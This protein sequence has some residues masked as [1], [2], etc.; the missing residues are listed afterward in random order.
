MSKNIDENVVEMRFDNSN[1]EKNVKTSMSTLDKL[2]QKLNLSGASK[3]LEELDKAAKGL[4]FATATRGVEALQLKI[5]NL[6]IVGVT[7]ISNITNSVINL[8]KSMLNTLTGISAIKSGF[9]EY[10]TQLGSIQTIMANTSSKGTTLDE[11]NA[12]LAELNHYADKT[13]YN[14]T[15]MTRNIGTFTAA[16]V[17]LN[18]AVSSIKG[19]ANLAAA[20]GSSS[21]QASTAMYQLSQA[22]AAGK[23]QLMDWNSVVNAGMGGEL[24][25]NALKRTAE[26]FGTDVDGM[27]QKYGSFRESLTN[28]GWLTVD[29]LTET[30]KQISGAYTEADLIAQGYTADQA[31]AI[32]EL[33]TTAENAATKVKTFAELWDTLTEAAGSGWTT[34]WSLIFGDFEYA[35]E[36]LT[37]FSD[38]FSNIIN[39]MSDARNSLLKPALDSNWDKLIDK[40][41]EAGVSSSD[42]SEKVKEHL[43]ENGEDV[44]ALLLEYGTLENA[45]KSGK[46]STDALKQAVDDLSVSYSDLSDITGVFSL[47]SGFESEQGSE[48]VKK[49][50]RQLKQLGYDLGTF[51]DQADG[52]DGQFGSMTEAAIKAFQEAHG[53]EADGII[54]PETLKALQDSVDK[55][56]DLKTSVGDLIDGVDELGGRDR[57]FKS[58]KNIITAVAKVAKTA[59]D[60]FSNIFPPATSEDIYNAIV[61]FE[62]FTEKLE[63][64]DETAQKLERVFAG[65]FSVVKIASNLI[66]GP[67]KIALRIADGICSLFGTSLLDL[68]AKI[69]DSIVAFSDWLDGFGKIPSVTN[70]VQAFIQGVIDT[71]TNLTTFFQNG[72]KGD[73]WSCFDPLI[74]GITALSDGIWQA[75]QDTPV[76]TFVNWISGIVESIKDS[77]AEAI[78]SDF[79]QGIVNGIEDGISLI[80]EWASNIANNLLNTVKDILGIHSPSTEG[81]AIGE[82][83]VQGIINGITGF[84]SNLID[85]VTNVGKTILDTVKGLDFGAAIPLLIIGG[86]VALL[87]IL[88][89]KLDKGV[90][91]VTGPF[92]DLA[93]AIGSIAKS[94]KTDKMLKQ[95]NAFKA[96]AEGIGI[97]SAAVLGLAYGISKDTGAVWGAVGVIATL[98]AVMAALTVVISKF[99]GGVSV[100]AAGIG[101]MLTGI[102]TVVASMAGVVYILGKMDTGQVIQGTIVCGVLAAFVVAIIG[103]MKYFDGKEK[104]G[105]AKGNFG[106]LLGVAIAIGAMAAVV[107]V[108][109]S[110]STE[111]VIR[112]VICAAALS[113]LIVALIKVSKSSEMLKG[114]GTSLLGVAVVLGVMAGM[115]FIFSIMNP[116][117]FWKGYQCVA[118]LS[119][120]VAGLLFVAGLAARLGSGNKAAGGLLGVAAVLAVMGGI[121]IILGGMSTEQLIKGISCVGLFSLFVAGLLIASGYAGKLSGGHGI[122]SFVGIALVLAVMAGCVILLGQMDEEKIQN[123]VQAMTWMSSLAAIL[124]AVSKKARNVKAGP[125]IALSVTIGLLAASLAVLSLMDPTGVEAA[126]RCMAEVMAMFVAVEYA[127]QFANSSVGTIVALTVAIG[128]IAFAIGIL[129]NITE[130]DSALASAQSISL[131]LVAM[132]AALAVCGLIKGV[133]T[134]SMAALGV[135]VAAVAL[136]AVI[137]GAMDA[138]NVSPS[139][140]TAISLAIMLGAM[141]IVMVALSAIGPASAGAIAAAGSFDAVV[142]IIGGLLVGLGAL[143]TYFPEAQQF[144]DTGIEILVSIGEGIGRAFGALIDGFLTQSTVSIEEIGTRLSNFMDNLQ[145]F[146]SGVENVPDNLIAKV[147]LV[148]GAILAICGDEIASAITDFFTGGNGGDSMIQKLKDLG[149]GLAEFTGSLSGIDLGALQIGTQAA[150]DIATLLNAIPTEGGIA[151]MLFGEKDLDGFFSGL[152]EYGTGLSTFA[153]SL[154]DMSFDEKKLNTV[155]ALSQ[156]LA[157]M[158]D[159]IPTTGGLMSMLF[160]EKNMGQFGTRAGEFGKGLYTFY[161]N[162]SGIEELQNG[163]AITSIVSI[164]GDMDEVIGREGGIIDKLTGT[165]QYDNFSTNATNFANGISAFATI[166]SGIEFQ[167]GDAITSIVGVLGDM[168]EVIGREGGIIDK[169]TGTVQYDGFSDNVTNFANGIGAFATSLGDFPEIPE[170]AMDNVT[171]CVNALESMSKILPKTGGVVNWFMGEVDFGKFG[172][173]AK[174]FGEGILSFA[175]AVKEI[176]SDVNYDNVTGATN[177]LSN[178]GNVVGRTGGVIGDLIEWFAGEPDFVSFGKNAALYGDAILSFA[179][180]CGGFPDNINFDQVSKASDSLANMGK[181]VGRDGGVIGDLMEWLVGKTDF[182]EFGHNAAAYAKALV[183]FGNA[184][185]GFPNDVNFDGVAVASNALGEMASVVDQGNGNFFNQ[186][187]DEKFTSFSENGVK[188]AKALKEF[189]TECVGIDGSGLPAAQTATESIATLCDSDALNKADQLEN[190][191]EKVASF[192]GKLWDFEQSVSSF[193]VDN[194]NSII[195]SM[196]TLKDI[197]GN[198]FTLGDIDLSGLSSALTGAFDSSTNDQMESAGKG[199]GTSLITG[200]TI[201]SD[202]TSS[203]TTVLSNAINK[204]YESMPLFLQNGT[205]LVSNMADGVKDSSS[206][207]SAVETICQEAANEADGWYDNF[208]SSGSYMVQGLIDGLNSK[209]STVRDTVSSIAS[210]ANSVLNR[211]VQVHSP[212]RKWMRT[213][214][215][216]GQGL[217]IGISSASLEVAKSTED[218]GELANDT[219]GQVFNSIDSLDADL[220]T[221]PV[222]RPV[223]DLSDIQNGAKYIDNMFGYSNA[224]KLN[225]AI[226]QSLNV[227]T[228]DDVINA[229][230]NLGNDIRNMPRNSYTVGDVSYDD[231]STTARAVSDLTRAV[232]IRRRS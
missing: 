101:V 64:S 174:K 92:S 177:A 208:Y 28:G 99:A 89:K 161:D 62:Q 55:T 82:N 1:F 205:E 128:L 158:N 31:K 154:G 231:G 162:V 126:T 106:S 137:L 87:A 19:I 123:G 13:I 26:H 112:G 171:D 44:D 179:T 189:A 191:G 47:G 86:I 103:L 167:N 91:N 232:K 225:S 73:F 183:D 149:T 188:Y 59:K 70:G 202:L 172:T 159:T 180:S 24:F 76:A 150:S 95:A 216:M 157:T 12:A 34:T 200:F 217:A 30:L 6:G 181:V 8:S 43:R 72:M 23:V 147:G 65:L 170:G 58:L 122:A 49:I 166:L 197:A 84:I 226:E 139:I 209:L 78:G 56:N 190:F 25:Q 27:I 229:I 119:A 220:D 136:I 40:I 160:G 48:D 36:N 10:Q 54:G 17:D 51:G 127:S 192:G 39:N 182:T 94:L 221:E 115:V 227:S 140:E 60:A 74:D 219:I 185:E 201:N 210:L 29:V 50:Q 133:S 129:A 113:V 143:V 111:E 110:M 146:L 118:A 35:R 131:V 186:L 135:I 3:G 80:V 15:E 184:C 153:T 207:S 204:I 20:S 134:S 155:S 132:A 77:G 176:P 97:L 81:V 130:A 2:K 4:T 178:M 14:F 142:A 88:G 79:V 156:A 85:T 124:I 212:S 63:I 164:L 46:I 41:T 213:G 117:A 33:A 145:P 152:G 68:A 42:F 199:L 163:D 71:F 187:S 37:W 108:L 45:F 38:Y 223:L 173:Q 120:L 5:S 61:K 22:I 206:L 198:G 16:G 93:D 195:S 105:S 214:R 18:T 175:N 151:G 83:F 107:K 116:D 32:S 193:N 218:L 75:L 9:A 169:L 230:S 67:L 168:D 144:L 100:D 215:F 102:A 141:S 121:V 194:F 148:S 211:T 125:L 138:L 21:M 69:A 66:G 109:G 7:A 96:F 228:N 11:V 114:M 52:V 90:K 57:I 104:F 165:V 196:Q 203:V 53:L 98:A 224:V 222:I